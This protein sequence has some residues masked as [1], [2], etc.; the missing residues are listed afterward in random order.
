MQNE[1]CFEELAVGMQAK[2]GRQDG[3]TR[4]T[5]ETD[6]QTDSVVRI[7]ASQIVGDVRVELSAVLKVRV[8]MS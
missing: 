7:N 3:P 8:V 6:R 5:P 4:A 1:G 2:P